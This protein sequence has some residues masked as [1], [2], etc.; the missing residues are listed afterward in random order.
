YSV[1]AQ[2]ISQ[3]LHHRPT[4]PK[5]TFLT[6][7]EYAAKFPMLEEQLNLASSEMSVI[8]YF[9]LDVI[10][11]VTVIALAALYVLWKIALT[12]IAFVRNIRKS[13]TKNE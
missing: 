8:T 2:E 1:R 12:G 7:I 4:T 11:L 5:D 9:C 6:H 3:M 10:A 13:K